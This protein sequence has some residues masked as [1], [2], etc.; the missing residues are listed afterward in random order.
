MG[1]VTRSSGNKSGKAATGGGKKSS[2]AKSASKKGTNAKV[3]KAAPV[4]KKKTPVKGSSEKKTVLVEACKVSI[5][6]VFKRCVALDIVLTLFL[7]IWFLEK[8]Q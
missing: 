5:Y 2:P 6:V 3:K 7:P 4:P 1:R 8:K